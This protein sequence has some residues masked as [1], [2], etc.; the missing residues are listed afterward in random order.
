M[1]K[2]INY[3]LILLVFVGISSCNSVEKTIK[4]GTPEQKLELAQKLY[5]KGDFVRAIQVYDELIVLYRGTQKIEDIYYNYAYAH[6]K[7]KDYLTA[8]YHFKYYA[9]TFPNSPKTEECL[10]MSAMCKYYDSP[11]YNLEQSSTEDAIREMQLFINLY[12]NSSRVAEATK[13]IDELRLKLSRKDFEKAKLY[14]DTEK[15][16][17]AAYAFEQHI[18]D[19]PSSIYKEEAMYLII[20]A[21]LDYAKKSVIEKQLERYQ[22]VVASY[23]RYLEKYPNGQYEKPALKAFKE[24]QLAMFKLENNK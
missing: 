2:K 8:S 16:K 11:Q 14:Y 10:Y 9:K 17:A 7:Q 1:I 3:L 21:N 19:F 23:N 15:Y 20:K 5:N 4:K 6:Y 12:P 24:A 22:L 18:K 13:I